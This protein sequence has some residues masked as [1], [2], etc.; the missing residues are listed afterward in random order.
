MGRAIRRT[1]APQAAPQ[2]SSSISSCALHS[3]S[4]RPVVE[5]SLRVRS[6]FSR[7]S[8]APQPLPGRFTLFAMSSR[9]PSSPIDLMQ[10]GER[11]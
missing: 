5:R 4:T 11:K 9:E 3:R 8:D 6:T 1:Q 7:S 10:P 2:S